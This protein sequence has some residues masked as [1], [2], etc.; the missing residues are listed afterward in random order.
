MLGAPAILQRAGAEDQHPRGVALDDHVG[1]Q[2][3]DELE[4]RDRHVELLALGR[5]GDRGLDAPVADPDA[6]GGD[7]VAALVERRH[8]D[9]EPV[10][11]LAE[12]RRVGDLDVVERDLGRVRGAQPELAVD[13]LGAVAVARGRDQERGEALVL[14]LGVGLG[15]HQ[16]DVGEVAHRDPHLVAADR[17]SPSP[18]SSR[19]CGGWRRPIRCRARSARSSRAPR[20]STGAG[21]T[22]ASAPRC[23]TARSSRRPARSG[24]RRR[25]APTSRRGRPARRSA[26]SSGS[27]GCGRRTPPRPGRPGSRPRR[28]S[29]RA[30]GRTC[31]PGRCRGRGG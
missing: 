5:V 2:L 12:H 1:D 31:R 28:A 25:S 29:S 17:S 8:R 13:L 11:D 27:R 23:P 21:A 14:L 3:L 6:A 19:G 30:R 16:R 9:L 26:R 24:P 22:P 20:P 15:E 7:A 10:A 18:S 4:A